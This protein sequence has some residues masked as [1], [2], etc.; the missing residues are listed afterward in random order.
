MRS[1]RAYLMPLTS[2]R[3]SA[4]ISASRSI[5]VVERL[6]LDLEALD[7][8]ERGPADLGLDRGGEVAHRAADADELAAGARQPVDLLLER[9]AHVRAQRLARLLR[10]R[11]VL[12][13]E[14]LGH[15]HGAQ[16][17][18][19]EPAGVAADDLDELHRA[20]AEVEHGAVGERRRVDRREV[21]VVG[22]LLAAEDAD[23]EAGLV[24]YAIEEDLPG[25]SRRGSRSSR[26]PGCSRGRGRSLRRN[27]RRPRRPRARAA[28]APCRACRSTPALRRCAPA[29]RS[30]R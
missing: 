1:A 7:A 29:G 3:S 4:G 5:E 20:A 22:L 8:A 18:R 28:S 27:A 25:C 6:A 13:E 24:A 12:G 26:R 30:R 2:P 23:R 15:P 16:R 17:P 9:L 11:V 19:A 21:A 10:R 14:V